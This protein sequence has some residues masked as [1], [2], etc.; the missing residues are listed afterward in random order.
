VGKKVAH[1]IAFR[2]PERIAPTKSW[3]RGS[4][5]LRY[6]RRFVARSGTLGY[7]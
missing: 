3:R 5:T 4:A 2:D 7:S 1:D 6:R